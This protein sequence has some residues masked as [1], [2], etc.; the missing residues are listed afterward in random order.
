MPSGGDKLERANQFTPGTFAEASDVNREFDDILA[1]LNTDAPLGWHRLVDDQENSIGLDFVSASAP[2]YKVETS[3]AVNIT[4]I[5]SKGMKIRVEQN[6][7]GTKYGWIITDPT[8]NTNSKTEFEI[9]TT[10]T[11]QNEAINNPCFSA[12]E[13]PHGFADNEPQQIYA[14]VNRGSDQN[15]PAD[16]EVTLN[17][18]N[19]FS[20][21][22][23]LTDFNNSRIIIPFSG[24]WALKVTFTVDGIKDNG[25]RTRVDTILNN[26]TNKR[27]TG[28]EMRWGNDGSLGADVISTTVNNSFR[29]S[30][31]DDVR[32][33][34]YCDDS[35]GVNIRGST[36]EFDGRSNK[37]MLEFIDF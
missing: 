19:T 23:G 30:K 16:S 25:A 6:T 22:Y 4:N 13:S 29:V 15:L 5:I 36:D 7:G 37:I 10:S 28:W 27:S 26:D 33:L 35:N 34:M 12:T 2:T 31:N 9:L 17:L 8:V 1:H 20:D 21:P 32:V 24:F 14:R 3:S 18:D 11:I